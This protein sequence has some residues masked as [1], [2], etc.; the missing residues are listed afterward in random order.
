[1]FDPNAY[2]DSGGNFE[3]VPP[4]DYMVTINSLER[5]TSENSGNEYLNLTLEIAEGEHEGIKFFDML[6]LTESSFWKVAQLCRAIG[7]TEPFNLDS[8]DEV[9]AVML[10]RTCK[11]KL[12]VE[13]YKGEK[14][15]RVQRFMPLSDAAK[16]ELRAKPPKDD[17]IGF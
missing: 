14:R 9:E 8:D 1:M 6:V 12:K 11:A 4:G 13:N 10:G 2:P 5:R 16:A 7:Q 3:A 17:D 15:N